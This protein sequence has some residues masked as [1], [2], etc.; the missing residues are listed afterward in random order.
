MNLPLDTLVPSRVAARLAEG[1]FGVADPLLG[2]DG[3]PIPSALEVRDLIEDFR[4]MLFPGLTDGRSRKSARGRDEIEER[5]KHIGARLTRQIEMAQL[6]TGVHEDT[7]GFE[8]SSGYAGRAAQALL[9]ELPRLRLALVEDASAAV[10][11]DPAAKSVA[12][13]ILCYP[14]HFAITVHRLAHILWN[15]KVPLLPRMMTEVAHRVTGIDLHPG[16]HIGA[17]F[18]IDHGTGVVVGETSI[19][20]AHVRIYQG[21]TLGALSVPTAEVEILR[22]GGKR[23]P[24][25]ED[26]VIV[27]AGATILGGDTVV[28]QSSIIEGN[29]WVAKSVP[30]GSRVTAQVEVHV[31]VSPRQK[32]RASQPPVAEAADDCVEVRR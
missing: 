14:G 21:V 32:G 19:I 9:A 4:E 18:F 29:A 11:G 10:A 31:R 16:A 6:A 24:T 7:N 25:L 22:A 2:V 15:L 13:V 23:H 20:G 27:Y 26:N 12:E 3:P 1:N 17:F 8:L 28:G 30:P 5:L